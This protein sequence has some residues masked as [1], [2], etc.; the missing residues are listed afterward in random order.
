MAASPNEL[1][2]YNCAFV[3]VLPK[4]LECCVCMLA[5]RDPHVL[6]CCGVKVC[7]S[8][9]GRVQAD[10]PAVCPKC[11]QRFV[12]M[13]EKE[14]QRSVL[15]LFVYCSRKKAG[16]E[17]KGELRKSTIHLQMECGYVEVECQYNCGGRFQRRL[18]SSHEME[19]CPQCPPEGKREMMT[20]KIDKVSADLEGKVV[21]VVEDL[22]QQKA[23]LADE[24]AEL[25]K[26]LSRLQSRLNSQEVGKFCPDGEYMG[27]MNAE[28]AL[29]HEAE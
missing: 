7:E 26:A 6:S 22:R 4:S 23:S 2:G 16:C 25:R 3:D 9:I 28:S 29:L 1:G 21:A 27:H 20:K 17:W 15:G 18:L 11:K 14:V 13:L 19:D 24:M 5:L 10:Q 12:T 8:C